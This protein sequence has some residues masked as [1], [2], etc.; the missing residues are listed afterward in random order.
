M[1]HLSTSLSHYKRPEIQEA[2]V[3]H[4]AGKE[5]AARF[6]D[7]FGKRPEVLQYPSDVL[8]MAK[9]GAT[10]FHCSEELWRNPLHLKPLMGRN[11]LDEMR[12]GWD[13]VLDVDCKFLEYSK[14][15]ADLIVKAL[16]HHK[17]RSLTAK[18]SGNHGFHIGIPFQSFPKEISG[19]ETRL[20]FPE[21]AKRIALYIKENT[22]TRLAEEILAL[23]GA[24]YNNVAKKTGVPV[25]KLS[26]VGE[27][28][29]AT[30]NV[31]P[32]LA[33]D[34]ILLSSRHMYRMPYSMHEKSGLVSI[35]VAAGEILEF[36]KESASPEKAAVS[37]IKFLDRSKARPS[38]EVKDFFTRAFD[39]TFREPEPE[40]KEKEYDVPAEAVPEKFFPP[41][42]QK[43]LLGVEDGRKR[44]LFILIN[45]LGS[46]GWSY[47]AMEARLTEW[48]KLNKQPIHP[49]YFLGQLRYHK[50]H[51]KKILPPNCDNAAYYTDLR[52]K[53][54]E[55]YCR[56]KNPVN[57][58]RKKS[59]R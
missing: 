27:D 18:F 21:A 28:N 45:F 44:A 40:R 13:L 58:A 53:C 8:E 30:L 20:L 34:T 42:I 5:V 55:E 7:N 11:E 24:K 23:E 50:Q 38:D 9:K 10:S 3:E 41:C 47:E 2:L 33:I 43:L 17:I 22:K 25:E 49:T 31:E 6:G 4:A 15:A 54:S 37:E 36:D 56:F 57:Y 32:F 48:N 39:A 51:R 35:P 16:S 59:S 1:I 26:C 52:V 19:T 46:C 29:K 14:I 12:T